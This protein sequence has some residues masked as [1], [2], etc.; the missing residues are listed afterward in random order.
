M[1]ELKTQL[2]IFKTRVKIDMILLSFGLLMLLTFAIV[3]LIVLPQLWRIG[4]LL[5]GIVAVA[6]IGYFFYIK[7]I[8]KKIKVMERELE[9]AEKRQALNEQNID[10]SH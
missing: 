4:L 8:K 2:K 3:V 5:L 6:V 7:Y 10:T 1:K 9:D